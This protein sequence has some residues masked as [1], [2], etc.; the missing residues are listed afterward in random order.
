[1]K[2]I[3]IYFF[4]ILIQ[5]FICSCWCFTQDEEASGNINVDTYYRGDGSPPYPGKMPELTLKGDWIM[6]GVKYGSE[7]ASFIRENFDATFTL[8]KQKPFGE[9]YL[10][11]CLQHFR[12]QIKSLSPPL[13]NFL[14][15]IATGAREE[16]ARSLYHRNLSNVDKILFLNVTREMLEYDAWHAENLGLIFSGRKNIYPYLGGT[17]WAVLAP[18]TFSHDIFIGFNRDLAYYPYLYQVALCVIPDNA[19]RF[20]TTMP[21]GWIGTD[22]ALNSKQLFIGQTIVRGE[23]RP[24]ERIREVDFGVPARVITAYVAAFCDCIDEAYEAL[25]A[26]NKNYLEETKRYTLMHSTSANYLLIDPRKALIVERTAHHYYKRVVNDSHPVITNCFICEDSFND[27]GKRT[28]VPMWKFGTGKSD[29]AAIPGL[30]RQRSVINKLK[31]YGKRLTIKE[32]KNIS[33]LSCYY[34]SDGKSQEYIL[35]STK[36]NPTRTPAREVG[37]SVANQAY[38]NGKPFYGTVSSH[39]IVLSA[40]SMEYVL[41][42]PWDWSGSWRRLRLYIW[43]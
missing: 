38:Y 39:L 4:L 34:D 31:T 16:L 41:G 40:L 19:N 29:P 9:E 3:G 30:S 10:K 7:A 1:M 17:C 25:T 13:Y 20:M 11:K 35:L 14:E 43:E 28:L 21:A 5:F 22:F 26:G 33:S 12:H 18:E 8:W 37:A 2:R 42:P 32:A 15:G 27:E 24:Q 23:F 6:M 36:Q